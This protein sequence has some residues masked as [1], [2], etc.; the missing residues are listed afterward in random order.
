MENSVEADVLNSRRRVLVFDP[1]TM[2]FYI[3]KASLV[4]FYRR[5]GCTK[6]RRYYHNNTLCSTLGIVFVIFS[7]C[8]PFDLILKP[9]PSEVGF[10]WDP[11][12]F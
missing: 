5:L 12:S 3:C 10:V 8:K 4:G 7:F 6:T 2:P 1:D 11:E 9:T